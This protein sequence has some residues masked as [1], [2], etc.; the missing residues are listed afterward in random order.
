MFQVDGVITFEISDVNDLPPRCVADTSDIIIPENTAANTQV[1]S[2][3]H[4]T[5]FDIS[6]N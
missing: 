6:N 1:T 2:K 5:E 3:L 4:I